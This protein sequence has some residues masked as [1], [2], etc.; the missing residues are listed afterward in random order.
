M[1]D[2]YT[3]AQFTY[4]CYIEALLAEGHTPLTFTP[5]RTFFN[6]GAW[7]KLITCG[8]DCIKRLTFDPDELEALRLQELATMPKDPDLPSL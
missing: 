5:K 3:T 7:V 4:N 8:K 2:N 6:S 1:T